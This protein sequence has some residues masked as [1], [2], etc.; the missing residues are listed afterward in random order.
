MAQGEGASPPL[1]PRLYDISCNVKRKGSLCVSRVWCNDHRAHNKGII[2]K[3]T[4]AT[5][6]IYPFNG[7]GR[8]RRSDDDGRLD[9]LGGLSHDPQWFSGRLMQIARNHA[10]GT[11][12]RTRRPGRPLTRPSM[13]RWRTYADCIVTPPQTD[14]T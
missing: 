2:L 11:A 6:I 3:L 14:G 5:L 13:G 4:Y 12:L 9:D 10:P 8:L 1:D 7:P